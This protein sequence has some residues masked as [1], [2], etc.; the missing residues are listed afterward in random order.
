[1]STPAPAREMAAA[2]A[3]T[4]MRRTRGRRLGPAW[5]DVLADLPLFEGLSRRHL[6]RV[7]DA[8]EE[9]RFLPGRTIIDIGRPGDS[10][11]VLID[12]TA[13]LEGCEGVEARLG[14]GDF[15][16]ELSLIDGGPRTARIT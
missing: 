2:I 13:R 9:A 6:R 15:F 11:F 8:A 16:G 5:A 7:A 14:P 12:G 1:M 3:A 4:E 10:F